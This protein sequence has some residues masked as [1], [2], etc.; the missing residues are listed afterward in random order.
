MLRP[1]QT[2]V[3]NY[4]IMG[5]EEVTTCRSSGFTLIELMI[6]VALVAILAAVAYPSYV[7]SVRKS[8]R[9]EAISA[10]EDV[11]LSQAKWRAN[12]A[13]YGTAAN[14]GIANRPYYNLAVTTN[15]ATAFTATATATGAQ[16]GDAGCTI[17][18]IN[19]N[20]PVGDAA[21]REK[22]WKR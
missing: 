13:T 7:D 5:D 10:L 20:G 22:C 21:H 6:V 3:A 15:T 9:A 16:A 14:I 11:R 12:N 17:L 18:T 8:R 2:G 19:Q 1:L 4:Q